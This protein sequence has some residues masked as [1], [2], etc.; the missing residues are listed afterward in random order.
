VPFLA[1]L[2]T[3]T[4]PLGE[5]YRCRLAGPLRH[6]DGDTVP[7]GYRTDLAST[8]RAFHWLLPPDGPYEAAAVRHDK[9]CDDLNRRL[10]G[11]VDPVTADRD[12]HAD[13]RALGMGPVR[14]RLMW[15]GVRL[16]ALLNPARRPGS[17]STAPAVAGLLLLFCWLA[18]P[19]L[20]VQAAVAVLDAAEPAP[21]LTAQLVAPTGHHEPTAAAAA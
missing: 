4:R 6:S 3:L 17:L 19:T 16:G 8:P 14:A 11:A 5:P 18:V 13:L 12:F 20:I 2:P 1:P 10:P 21:P 7:D 9:R 15:L